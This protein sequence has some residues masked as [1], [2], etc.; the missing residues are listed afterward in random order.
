MYENVSRL[1]YGYWLVRNSLGWLVTTVWQ[2]SR[3]RNVDITCHSFLPL[4][5]R[6]VGGGEG[7][8]VQRTRE[9]F[10]HEGNTE[11]ENNSYVVFL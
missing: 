8:G 11:E 5:Q 2:R 1:R 6:P 9:V 4:H 3:G 10:R 7:G